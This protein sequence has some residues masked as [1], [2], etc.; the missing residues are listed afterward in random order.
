MPARCPRTY[1]CVLTAGTR[2]DR[3]Y[4]YRAADGTYIAARPAGDS[5]PSKAR[6]CR[7]VMDCPGLQISW[8]EF[9]SY[10]GPASLNVW[11]CCV[12]MS[13]R[14][15]LVGCPLQSA[16]FFSRSMASAGDV[17]ISFADDRLQ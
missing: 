6:R 2:L 1:L 9:V 16:F 12:S 14:A 11:T 5:S 4:R 3:T 15:F 7:G 13:C 8:T 17:N 10:Q